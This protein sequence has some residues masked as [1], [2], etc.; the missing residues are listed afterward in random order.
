[1]KCAAWPCRQ[2]T[3]SLR[4]MYRRA[5]IPSHDVSPGRRSCVSRAS[6]TSER[7]IAQAVAAVMPGMVAG[8]TDAV[9]TMAE[10][11]SYGVP[12]DVHVRLDP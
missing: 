1:M 11:L 5:E 7:W 2:G 12:W 6:A 4:Y 8:M 9:C 10:L 3:V